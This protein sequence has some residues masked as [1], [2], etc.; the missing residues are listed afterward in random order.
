MA[1]AQIG[2]IYNNGI[3][4][5][6]IVIDS[7]DVY[8]IKIKFDNTNSIR[9]VTNYL[10]N[11]FNIKDYMFPSLCGVGYIGNSPKENRKHKLHE[12]ADATWRNVIKRCYDIDIKEKNPS[13]IDATMCDEWLNYQVFLKWFE[14]NYIDGWH[15]D[16]DLLFFGNKHYSP[17]TC[18]FV[19][20][21]VNN[22]FRY[23]KNRGGLPF[24][25]K[26]NSNKIGYVAGS[27]CG[28]KVLYTNDLDLA[29]DFYW[30]QKRIA[31]DKVIKLYPEFSELL[32][33]YYE[34]FY[35]KYYFEL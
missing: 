1:R 35:D 17:E 22:I 5:K 3:Y 10:L 25:I 2:D 29:V 16:K 7:P 32:D 28:N 18:I 21:K 30:V 34:M 23:Q 20:R 27:S 14:E 13:Y 11:H 12:K 9:V 6:C 31:V 8:N 4:G 24:G 33:K 26:H 15:I 19:P